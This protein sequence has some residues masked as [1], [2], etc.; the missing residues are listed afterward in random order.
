MSDPHLEYVTLYKCNDGISDP[1]AAA[2]ILFIF[3]LFFEMLAL[4]R[5]FS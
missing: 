2:H 5:S 1:A 4:T 3:S